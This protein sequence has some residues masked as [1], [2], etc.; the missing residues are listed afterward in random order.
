MGYSIPKFFGHVSL[1]SGFLLFS[2]NAAALK[3]D[4]SHEYAD[5]SKKQKDITAISHTFGNGIAIK[6]KYKFLPRKKP[7]GDAGNAFDNDKLDQREY[8][9][10]Y[11]WKLAKRWKVVPK[12]KY[13]ISDNKKKYKPQFM[14]EYKT[15]HKIKIGLGYQYYQKNKKGASA[16]RSHDL[17]AALSRRFGPLKIAYKYTHYNSSEKIFNHHHRD[18]KHELKA[19]YALTEH[20]SPYIGVKNVSVDDDTS[21]RETKSYVGVSY[22]F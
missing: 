9:I 22:T 10:K 1:L 14:V 19:S 2:T 6:A 8:E 20:W 15:A 18:F 17:K 7:N 16:V 5:R 21:A 12:F 4:Y 11:G 3:L 13:V